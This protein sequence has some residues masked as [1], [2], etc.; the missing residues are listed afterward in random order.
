MALSDVK[1]FRNV[2][3][4]FRQLAENDVFHISGRG[5]PTSG[6]TGSG[7][8]ICG[9]QSTY[10]D[11]TNNILYLQVGTRAIPQW[12]ALVPAL[13]GA[14]L[15]FAVRRRNTIAEVEAGV[16]LL[17]AIPGMK[18]RLIDLI[19]IAIGGAA[20]GSTDVRVLGTQAAGSVALGIAA[21]A[22]LTQSTVLR[23]GSP[24]ATAGTASIV[25]LAG[26]ASFMQ[27]DVN[28]AITVGKTGGALATSTHIDT[29][30]HYAIE[31]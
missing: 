28:T 15:A 19:M 12:V 20:S 13:S 14:G 10:R 4:W 6:S 17:A 2:Q 24:F 9:P 22:G 16:T 18:Y 29:I 21:V 11:V 8:N 30:A 25:A 7:V 5:A 23:L 26:G 27:N 1:A 3:A 31:A